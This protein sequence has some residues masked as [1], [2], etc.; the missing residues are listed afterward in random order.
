MCFALYKAQNL[1]LN[2]HM[3][4]EE[5]KA[6]VLKKWGTIKECA[7][8]IG[9]SYNTLQMALNGQNPLTKA[10]RHHLEL[11]LGARECM[12][13]YKVNT[14][15]K[16]VEELTAGKGCTCERDRLQAMQGIIAHNMELLAK[17]GANVGWTPEQLAA[18]GVEQPERL[19]IQAT[20]MPGQRPMVAGRAD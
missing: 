7:K 18:W 2:P 11:A 16:K 3:T 9:V 12:L 15:T 1:W 8:E 19:S 5:L 13:L 17:A 4:L 14:T 6:A 10:L 20:H